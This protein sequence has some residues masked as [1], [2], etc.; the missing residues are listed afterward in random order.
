[1]SSEN[2]SAKE[3]QLGLNAA[4]TRRDFIGSALLGA[5]GALLGASAPALAARAADTEAS[6]SFSGLDASWTGPGGL[7]DYGRANGNTH[8]IVNAG[9]AVFSGDFAGRL[10]EAQDSGETYDL[11][12]VGVAPRYASYVDKPMAAMG[13]GLGADVTSA[14][15]ARSFF[16][17]GLAAFD[18][19]EGYPDAA[20]VAALVSFPGG[21]CGIARHFVKALIPDVFPHA[22]RLNDVLTHA[23]NW[24]ALDN[25][26]QAVRMRLSATVVNV[27]HEGAADSAQCRTD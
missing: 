25:P 18:I 1:M 27:E 6:R 17:P 4:I 5:G 16:Q 13:C 26:G 11:V 2:Q 10:D 3:Q 8:Q 15:T 24:P 9:H 23:I 14:Y 12:V 21:N 7:G 22:K 20:D 19:R